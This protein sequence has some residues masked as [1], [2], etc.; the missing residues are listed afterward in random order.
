MLKKDTYK[1]P[2][3]YYYYENKHFFVVINQI[4]K[5]KVKIFNQWM[6]A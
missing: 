1:P 6:H 5:H 3:K 4:N 2:N